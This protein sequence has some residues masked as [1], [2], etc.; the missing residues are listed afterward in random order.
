MGFLPLFGWSF[1]RKESKCPRVQIYF[2]FPKVNNVDIWS[3]ERC[4]SKW[5]GPDDSCMIKIYKN[6]DLAIITVDNSI[7]SVVITI[8]NNIDSTIITILSKE[9]NCR[10]INLSENCPRI[11]H[12]ISIIKN[13]ID[14]TIDFS[15]YLLINWWKHQHFYDNSCHIHKENL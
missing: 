3:L 6:I 1:D 15:P 9:G 7:D 10:I 11:L 5:K 12:E 8:Y 14:S 4:R 13:Y 2:D